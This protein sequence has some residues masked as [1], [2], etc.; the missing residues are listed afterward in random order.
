MNI[1]TRLEVFNLGEEKYTKEFDAIQFAT[2]MRDLRALVKSLLDSNER[3]L[4]QNQKSHCLIHSD[5]EEEPDHPQPVPKLFT[6]QKEKSEHDAKI[7]EFM[8]IQP[9]LKI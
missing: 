8:V 6:T 9:Q 1:H 2:N 3:F 7:S 5:S 4:L